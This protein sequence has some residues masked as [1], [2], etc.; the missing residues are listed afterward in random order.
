MRYNPA[1][2]SQLKVDLNFISGADRGQVMLLPAMGEDYAATE[3]AVRAIDVFVDCL[4][5]LALGFER[6]ILTL[7]GRPAYDPRDML[8]RYIYGYLDGLRSSRRLERACY[9]NLEPIWLLRKRAL[10][11]KTIA[12][13][14]R[15]NGCG[16]SAP[17]APSCNS[18]A[19]PACSPAHR[20][21]R[22]HQ[23]ARRRQPKLLSPS[24]D[25]TSHGLPRSSD[26]RN[27]SRSWHER[28]QPNMPRAPI[29]KQGRAISFHT[30]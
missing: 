17:V 5:M 4:D 11:F 19:R 20:D 15:D 3:A 16:S 14:R 6:P 13:F 24:S 8:R 18:A 21:D 25:T 7:T 22:R 12:D 23:G 30:A 1:I 27:S 9:I 28:G 2:D 10:D 26:A 29:A